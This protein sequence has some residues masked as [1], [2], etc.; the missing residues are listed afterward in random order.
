M[1]RRKAHAYR[2]NRKRNSS[3][4]EPVGRERK[5]LGRLGE[6]VARRFLLKKG[7]KIL[8]TNL[9]RREGELD[10]VAMDGAKIV[11]VEVKT[12]TLPAAVSPE[13][14]F[15]IK[16]QKNLAKTAISYLRANR[17][18]DSEVRFDFLAIEIP[19][20]GEPAIRHVEEAFMPGDVLGNLTM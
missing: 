1:K 2:K 3:G 12:V 16:K 13:D 10:I 19:P 18:E 7:L 6:D 17:L 8:R 4:I 9:E 5:D 11:F 20:G 15:T 14:Q